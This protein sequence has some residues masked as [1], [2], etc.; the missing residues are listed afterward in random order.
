ML[1]GMIMIKAG[2]IRRIGA[3]FV[4]LLMIFRTIIGGRYASGKV[5]ARAH[6]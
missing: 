2:I 4:M 5:R 6:K 1:V 3:A